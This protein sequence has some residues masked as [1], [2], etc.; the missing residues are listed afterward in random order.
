MNIRR[1]IRRT[2][3]VTGILGFVS[4]YAII[5]LYGP[6]PYDLHD[7]GLSTFGILNGWSA[8]GWDYWLVAVGVLSFVPAG[9]AVFLTLIL[10]W[11]LGGFASRPDGEGTIR[12]FF[13]P[14]RD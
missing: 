12:K 13:G 3:V 4:G 6:Q 5:M 14:W 8:D 10:G 7:H 9:A 1:G 2:A 11:V